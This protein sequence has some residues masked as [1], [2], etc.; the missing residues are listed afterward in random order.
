MTMN[1]W[2]PV[3]GRILE[4]AG[5]LFYQ[6]GLHAVGVDEIVER[7]GV[8]TT[9]IYAHFTSKAL[10]IARCLQRRSAAWQRCRCHDRHRCLARNAAAGIPA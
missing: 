9:T 2:S 1:T 6:R 8:A 4:A 10:L 5:A 7:S 3:W